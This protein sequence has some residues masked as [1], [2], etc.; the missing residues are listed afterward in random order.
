MAVKIGF[1][2]Y[3]ISEFHANNYPAWIRECCEK[4]G[5][6]Y[7]VSYMWAEREISPVDGVGTDEWC[8]KMG[9]TRCA[10][11]EEVCEKSDVLLVLAPSDPQT[12]LGYAEKVLPYRKRTYIDKTFAPDLATA[13]RI[14]ALAEQY[15][16][17]FFSTSALR[18]ADELADLPALEHLLVS[19]SGSNFEEYIIHQTEMVV[20]VL[21]EPVT[22]VRVTKKGIQRYCDLQTASGK[23]ATILYAPKLP[24]VVTGEDGAGKQYGGRVKS[25]FFKNLTSRILHFYESGIPPFDIN[26][27]LEVQR[28]REWLM[29]ADAHPGEWIIRG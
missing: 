21:K 25:E 24:Y 5:L 13:K 19:G 16:T 9:V 1:I 14:F 18:Y 4:E 11:I 15:A 2:D 28:L 3:Y 27:I 26:E 29:K 20:A 7:T 12:H 17:P 8:A 22:A 23:D 10:S 6:D